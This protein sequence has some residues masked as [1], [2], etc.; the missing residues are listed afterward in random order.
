MGVFGWHRRQRRILRYLERARG[1]WLECAAGI[2]ARERSLVP[3]AM[4][5]EVAS[6]Q[7]G[8]H[9][10]ETRPQC[11][12]NLNIDVRQLSIIGNIQNRRVCCILGRQELSHQER[13]VFSCRFG[14]VDNQEVFSRFHVQRKPPALLCQHLRR[15]DQ[16]PR[17]GGDRRL[18]SSP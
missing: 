3:R 15:Y 2:S 14:A 5:Q 16:A 4:V 6:D 7:P 8:V 11:A 12:M 1:P 17:G 13:N 9:L 10:E 18:D